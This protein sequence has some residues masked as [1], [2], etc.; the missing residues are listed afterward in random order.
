MAAA[1]HLDGSEHL[2]GDVI[3]VRN[4]GE[5]GWGSEEQ[6]DALVQNYRVVFS[7]TI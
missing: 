5:D 6:A 2:A 1:L 7:G 3:C 4:V